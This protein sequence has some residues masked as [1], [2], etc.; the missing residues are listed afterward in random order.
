MALKKTCISSLQMQACKPFLGL[1][2][3]RAG[4][5][6]GPCLGGYEFMIRSKKENFSENLNFLT[7]QKLFICKRIIGSRTIHFLEVTNEV[8]SNK[9]N[10]VGQVFYSSNFY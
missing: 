6:Q 7:K 1:M 3:G 9:K 8:P 4:S 5:L 10:Y 2:P